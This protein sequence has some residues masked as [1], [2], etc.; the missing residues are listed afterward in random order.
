MDRPRVISTYTP[1]GD[2]HE[3]DGGYLEIADR[4]DFFDF[5]LTAWK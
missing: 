1:T 2:I 5:Q 4:L 3:H